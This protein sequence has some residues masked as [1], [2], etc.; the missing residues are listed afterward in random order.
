[1]RQ[2]ATF[3]FSLSYSTYYNVQFIQ[4]WL[5]IN[6]RWNNRIDSLWWKWEH[7]FQTQRILNLNKIIINVNCLIMSELCPENT[8][9]MFQCCW[10]TSPENNTIKLIRVVIREEKKIEISMLIFG[11]KRMKWVF[12]YAIFLF[13]F[14]MR[15]IFKAARINLLNFIY[16]FWY[17]HQKNEVMLWLLLF[18]P[19]I[20]SIS[21]TIACLCGIRTIEMEMKDARAHEIRVLPLHI[22]TYTIT[23][24]TAITIHIYLFYSSHLLSFLFNT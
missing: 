9:N 10:S 2:D 7:N 24:T 17:V 12:A 11:K 16:A 8:N 4:M 23:T 22:S 1:M 5:K 6:L 14:K 20:L 13:S 21:A 3:S 18:L 15:R 19:R